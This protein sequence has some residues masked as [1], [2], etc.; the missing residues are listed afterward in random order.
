MRSTSFTTCPAPEPSSR[1]ARPYALAEIAGGQAEASEACGA[2]IVGGNLARGPALSIATTV[3]GTCDGPVLRRGAREGD[4]LW[5][6]GPVGLA[7][8]GMRAIATGRESE[9]ALAGAVAAWRRPVARIIQGLAMARLAHAAIDVSDGLARDAAHVAQASG[10][11]LVLDAGAIAAERA[12]HEAATAMGVD[13]LDLALHGGEDYAL[14]A[15]SAAPIDGF[16]R[17]GEVV[18]GSGVVLRTKDRVV[19]LEPRGY[20]HFPER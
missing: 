15:S 9:A 4:A 18:A 11:R 12:L 8:A 2:P 3:L 17:V 14:L 1:A 6:A 13:S 20:D 19:P 7:A 10:V 16:R 5:L